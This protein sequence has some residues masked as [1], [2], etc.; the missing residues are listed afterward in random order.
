MKKICMF[1]LLVFLVFVGEGFVEACTLYGAAG[2]NVEGGGT[3]LAKNRDWRPDHIQLL[4]TVKPSR[5]YAYLALATT[6]GFL[7][8]NKAG[9]NEKG[10]TIVS[11]SPPSDY[12]NELFFQ[13]GTAG[14]G[15][16]LSRYKSVAEAV[17]ALQAKQWIAGPQ[18]YM[19]ADG[20]EV[21]YIEF[22]PDR[23]FAVK[24]TSDGILA[25]TN[26]YLEPEMLRFNPQKIGSSKPRLERVLML[27]SAQPELTFGDFQAFA[28]DP[29]IWRSATVPFGTRTLAGFQIRIAPDGEVSIWTRI[30]NPGREAYELMFSLRDALAGKIEF[31]KE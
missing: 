4:R 22:G 17:D 29:V 23:S 30:S 3:I 5:G 27:M 10:L 21:A 15:T 1:V 11:A 9:V 19:L 12:E 14:I 13:G 28:S 7:T 8:G 31:P 2:S 6:S 25:H 26:H 20:K 16:V 18:A 24:R